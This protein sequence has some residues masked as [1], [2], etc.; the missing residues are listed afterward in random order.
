MLS[1]GGEPMG[2]QLSGTSHSYG[3]LAMPHVH[4][5][6]RLA[7]AV[8][9]LIV[10]LPASA[11]HAASDTTPPTA[12]GTPVF[13]QVTPFSVTL[14]W[15]PST[16]N[17]AVTWYLIRRT[18]PNGGSWNDSIRATA[19]T[20][21]IGHLTPNNNYTFTVIATDAAA[22]TAA[23]S[24]A[25]VRTPPYTDGPMCAVAYQPNYSSG[26][27]F[28]A[29][30]NMTNLSPG[31]WQEWTLAFTLTPQQRINPAWGFRQ[32]ETRWSA[33]F[34]WLWSSGAGPLLPGYSRSVMFEG[35]YTGTINPPPT[36]FTINDHP[37][38]AS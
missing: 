14:T 11:A 10:M 18:L 4:T 9:A 5:R 36:E 20:I 25:S 3:E 15:T 31:P 35:S 21:T 32:D 7:A 17:V 16:D 8:A 30:V 26:G 12:P 37:C 23:S 34:V 29:Q 33:T 2:M 19:N 28:Y 6:L 1:Y 13:S 22:N 24:A 27:R 38:T